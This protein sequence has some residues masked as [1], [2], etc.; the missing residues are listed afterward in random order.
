[1]VAGIQSTIYGVYLNNMAV[2]KEAATKEKESEEWWGIKN[3]SGLLIKCGQK[4]LKEEASA[5]I[6]KLVEALLNSYFSSMQILA[7]ELRHPGG[8]ATFEKY[9]TSYHT[10]L[11]RYGANPWGEILQIGALLADSQ[12]DRQTDTFA[13][14]RTF[15][16]QFGMGINVANHLGNFAPSSF[17]GKDELRVYVSQFGD[18]SNGFLTLPSAYVLWHGKEADQDFLQGLVG[19]TDLMLSMQYRVA[20]IICDSGAFD[21]CLGLCKAYEKVAKG[22]LHKLPKSQWR[23]Y[24]SMSLA[25][26]DSNKYIKALKRFKENVFV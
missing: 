6:Q 8:F 25:N 3:L 7:S 17:F 24:L 19:N 12:P 22:T 16:E 2:Y 4:I 1:M 26:L 11:H 9:K 23:D 20:R 18:L 15:G 21:Y 14:L 13:I 5:D 10:F